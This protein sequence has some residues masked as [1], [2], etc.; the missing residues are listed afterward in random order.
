MS[1]QP[2][3]YKSTRGISHLM[4]ALITMNILLKK[5]KRNTVSKNCIS[6]IVFDCFAVHWGDVMFRL[7]G[8]NKV[9]EILCLLFDCVS[10]QLIAPQRHLLVK[11]GHSRV[12]LQRHFIPRHI[13]FRR[14]IKDCKHGL[15]SFGCTQIW[16]P[17]DVFTK[18]YTKNRRLA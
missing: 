7:T 8:W 15:S 10:V 1:L 5:R 16:T 4:F 11:I 2:K 18:Q 13:M 6:K 3:R 14:T 9:D 17:M 12:K